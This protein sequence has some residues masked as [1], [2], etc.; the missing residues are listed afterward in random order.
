VKTRRIFYVFCLFFLFGWAYTYAKFPERLI[1]YSFVGFSI[2][3]ALYR[4]PT[5]V[6]S[7]TLTSFFLYE[8]QMPKREF[9][10]TLVTTNVGFFSSVA[11]SAVLI[12]T[13]GIGPAVLAVFAWV[14]GLLW[15]SHSVPKLIEF[16]RRGATIHEY[17]AESY[18]RNAG[19]KRHLRFYSSF[20][21]FLLYVA[22]VGA[23]IKFTADVFSGPT[24]LNTGWLALALSVA[25]VF[26]VSI[27]GYRGVVS[28]DRLRFWAILTGVAAVYFFIGRSVALE[29]LKLPSEFTSATM[30]TI[31]SAPLALLSLLVL[32][33]VYQFCVMD[34]WERCIAI[35]NSKLASATDHPDEA[36]ARNIRRMIAWSILPFIVLFG[37]WYG[38]GILSLGQHWVEDPNMIIPQLIS[39]LN[40]FSATGLVG[41][42]TETLIVL[43]FSAAALSTIDGFII[44]AVQTIIF[45]WLPSFTKGH[46]E[47]NEIDAGEARR[48]LTWSRSLV[49]LVGGAA[50]LIAYTSFNIMSFWVGMYS[51]MLAFFPAIIFSIYAGPGF[52]SRRTAFQVALS[53]VG[54]AVCALG[55]AIVGTFVIPSYAF[56]TA[57]PPFVAI[58]VSS[59]LLLPARSAGYDKK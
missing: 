50:V 26:Y 28:T 33:G 18:G 3:W 22:S 38:I 48:W 1:A 13:M 27:S 36:I 58:G 10:G 8:R 43:C 12:V 5:R 14:A 20:I 39:R 25:G 40:A 24:G 29:G 37:A 17:I 56:L 11:F 46:Q 59:V 49:V 9:I 4:L 15:F 57:L 53:I 6:E 51:L 34:M 35:V 21:T 54:G 42:I 32:L 16:F 41:A 19:Q 44:A 2:A 52:R 55:I 7:E 47:W 45:D 31:G 30:L 23:E